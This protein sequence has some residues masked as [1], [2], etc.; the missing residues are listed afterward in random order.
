[1]YA[2]EVHTPYSKREIK[3]KFLDIAL[4]Q[5]TVSYGS[6]FIFIVG[7]TERNAAGA[8]RPV[9]RRNS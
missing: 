4:L 6:Y 2:L 5:K 1:M 8:K 7:L 3:K 9:D